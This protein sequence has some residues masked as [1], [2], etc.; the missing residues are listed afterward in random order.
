MQWCERVSAAIRKLTFILLL[1]ASTLVQAQPADE[2]ERE[3]L[4][5]FLEKTIHG[6]DSF[7]DRF[8]A[9]VWLVDMSGR[10]S[11]YVKDPQQRLELLRA[12]HASAS[13][14]RCSRSHA[15]AA[16]SYAARFF[17]SAAIASATRASRIS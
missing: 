6:A 2:Q 16:S 12:I 5:A 3:E 13:S 11:R 4:R 1:L 17:G 14:A 8:D 9:E 15:T 10:L 7:A